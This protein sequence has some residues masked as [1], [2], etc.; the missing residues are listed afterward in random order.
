MTD[1]SSQSRL[2]A[3]LGF[4]KLPAMLVSGVAA[5]LL[6]VL[7]VVGVGGTFFCLSSEPVVPYDATVPLAEY[8]G[9]LIRMQVE[10]IYHEGQGASFP[11]FGVH[12]KGLAVCCVFRSSAESHTR[13]HYNR[14]HGVPESVQLAPVLRCADFVLKVNPEVFLSDEWWPRTIPSAEYTMPDA[15]KPYVLQVNERDVLLQAEEAHGPTV[16][17]SLYYIPSSFCGGLHLMGRVHGNV[18]DLTEPGCG[19]IRGDEAAANTTHRFSPGIVRGIGAVCWSLIMV[20]LFT[21][22]LVIFFVKPDRAFVVSLGLAAAAAVTLVLIGS[23][24]FLALAYLAQVGFMAY[25]APWLPWV[26]G[27]AAL[28]STLGVVTLCRKCR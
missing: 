20:S 19:F 4:M 15:L 7:C 21:I 28:L 11:L 1:S 12:D 9:K 24:L 13:V 3:L 2:R 10:R 5:V 26:V 22:S 27:F 18:L 16:N 6:F 17:M 8:D 14:V 25:M 23:T